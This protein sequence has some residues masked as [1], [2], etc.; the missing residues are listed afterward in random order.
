MKDNVNTFSC[1]EFI[2][3]C[4]NHAVNSLEDLGFKMLS[5]EIEMEIE[6]LFSSDLT[7][8]YNEFLRNLQSN[9]DD[10]L[11]FYLK[12]A[13]RSK[14]PRRRDFNSLYIKYCQ[15][16]F[17]GR[18]GAEKFDKLDERIN[19]FMEFNKNAKYSYQLYNKDQNSA[20]TPA[21]ATPLMLC[22]EYIKR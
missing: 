22:K 9:S 2:E 12:K 4:H 13:D 21:I 1:N 16:K 7:Q 17:G 18:N 19:E 10:E 14:C 5:T 15:E 3:H 6:A 20:L 11:N 8:A